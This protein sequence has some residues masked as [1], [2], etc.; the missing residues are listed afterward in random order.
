MDDPD[1]DAGPSGEGPTVIMQDD[2]RR[3]VRWIVST[4]EGKL[5]LKHRFP[6]ALRHHY[7]PA[8]VGEDVLLYD[9]EFRVGG[10]SDPFDGTVRWRWAERP[11]IEAVR[12]GR[13]SADPASVRR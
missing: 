10:D 1:P 5:E 4:P 8:A 12:W 7:P 6:D 2:G 3:I 11:R 13:R 9:G